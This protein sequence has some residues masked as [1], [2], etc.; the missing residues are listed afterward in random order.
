M[1]R[2]DIN[3]FEDDM[4]FGLFD[5]DFSLD[6]NDPVMIKPAATVRRSIEEYMEEKRLR[7]LL[8]DYDEDDLDDWD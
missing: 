6:E 1:A 4:D 5:A 2:S 3:Q 8:E 7:D